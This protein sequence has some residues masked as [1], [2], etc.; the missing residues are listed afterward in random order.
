[1]QSVP[2]VV[3]TATTE[4]LWMLG[5]STAEQNQIVSA[6]D[7][8]VFKWSGVHNVYRFQSKV[9]F[10]V[11]DFSEA[12]ELASYLQT[13]YTYKATREGTFFFACKI[14]GHCEMGQKMSLAVTSGMFSRNQCICHTLW[15]Y[16]S[17][18][19]FMQS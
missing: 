17:L 7:E 2:V 4:I 1:M 11:C 13:S 10:D 3:N 8:V 9:A 5:M 12:V 14:P 15:L 18:L 6:G 19:V 16:F